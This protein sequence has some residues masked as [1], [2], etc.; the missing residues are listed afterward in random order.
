MTVSTNDPGVLNHAAL[1]LNKISEPGCCKAICGLSGVW[2]IVMFSIVTVSPGFSA[3]PDGSHFNWTE[4]VLSFPLVFTLSD[5]RRSL[6][7]T[8]AM[9]VVVVGGILV[10][11]VGLDVVVVAGFVVVT[12]A[13]PASFAVRIFSPSDTL[14][15]AKISNVGLT[16]GF[17]VALFF[18]FILNRTSLPAVTSLLNVRVSF[19]SA[20]SQ[21]P[22][23]P[24]TSPLGTSEPSEPL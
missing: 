7:E 10:V 9:V 6:K 11:V 8:G 22:L 14:S 15:S 5:T 2:V 12:A 4:I 17:S 21:A 24:S 16:P 23:P 19:P 20:W 13:C 1:S 3:R 18:S